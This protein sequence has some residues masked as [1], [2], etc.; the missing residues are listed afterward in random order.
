MIVVKNV[1]PKGVVGLCCIFM[2]ALLFKL[3]I[4]SEYLYY[5]GKMGIPQTEAN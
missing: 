4:L 5:L 2:D 1:Y 3:E